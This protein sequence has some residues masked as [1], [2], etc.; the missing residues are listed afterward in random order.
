MDIDNDDIGY[1]VKLSLPSEKG[2]AIV[3][4]V[5]QM[6]KRKAKSVIVPCTFIKGSICLYCQRKGR[7]LRS[8]QNLPKD[9]KVNKFD[10]TS[11]KVHYLTL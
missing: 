10:S 9:V 11:G 6:V 2:S 3:N 8:C 1:L 7:W 4:S 5:D